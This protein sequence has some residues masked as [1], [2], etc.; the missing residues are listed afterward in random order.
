[1]EALRCVLFEDPTLLH[2]LAGIVVVVSGVAYWRRRGRGWLI[3]VGVAA[4]LGVGAFFLARWVVTDR[5]Q[6]IAALGEIAADV[7][8]GKV[9]AFQRHLDEQYAGFSYMG[10]NLGKP[11]A[12]LLARWVNATYG[13]DQ[14]GLISPSVSPEGDRAAAT[15][16]T[17]LRFKRPEAGVDY[18]L[19]RWDT[20]WIRRRDGWKI[21]SAKRPTRGL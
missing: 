20:R 21:L 1:M 15:F 2:I 18:I 12:V 8:R 14:V 16:R 6:I 10:F 11:G 4:A 9:D 13:F 7:E 17:G 19:L 5:E 3:A